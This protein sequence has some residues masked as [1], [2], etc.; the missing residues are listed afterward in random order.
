MGE[1]NY[2]K[3]F[4]EQKETKVDKSGIQEGQTA[5]NP[6]TNEKMIYRGGKWQKI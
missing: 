3:L 4:G 1:N 6:K 5:T 2:K